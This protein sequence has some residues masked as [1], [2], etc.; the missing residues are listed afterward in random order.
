MATKKR[1]IL[2]A[3]MLLAVFAVTLSILVLLPP[4]P[5]VTKANFDRIEKGMTVAEVEEIFGRGANIVT[6]DVVEKNDRFRAWSEADGS[7]ADIYFMDSFVTDK[8]WWESNETLFDKIR[9]WTHLP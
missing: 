7:R 4:S 5:G 9:R 1:L 3:A 8:H 6:R 2:I